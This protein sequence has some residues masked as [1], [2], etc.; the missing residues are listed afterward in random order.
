M[1]VT[2]NVSFSL[3]VFF[4][5]SLY[6][7]DKLPAILRSSEIADYKLFLFE[8]VKKFRLTMVNRL[9]NKGPD[10][11]YELLHG[12]EPSMFELTRFFCSYKNAFDNQH[13]KIKL[14]LYFNPLLHRYSFGRIN[15]RQLL[16]TLWE[17]EKLLVMSNFSP[18]HNVFL[19][20]QIFVCPFV[21]ILTSYLYLQLNLKSL[22]LAYQVKG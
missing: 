16:K 19:L 7:I 3:N 15:N 12:F 18:S 21:T 8:R 13:F 4:F 10:R 2:S 14:N 6:R 11:A 1:L 20:N 17:K 9:Y 22:N 5:L